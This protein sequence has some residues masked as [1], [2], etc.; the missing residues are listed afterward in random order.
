MEEESASAT[1]TPVQGTASAV[2]GHQY[3]D[4]RQRNQNQTL[5]P[6]TRW[7]ENRHDA[8]VFII[9]DDESVGEEE[10]EEDDDD[11]DDEPE[12]MVVA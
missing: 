4:Q 3:F 6:R 7:P 11:D 8:G 9:S 12:L 5:V 10:E 2:T 1:S